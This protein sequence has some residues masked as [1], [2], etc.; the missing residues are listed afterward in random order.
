MARESL[1]PKVRTR[2]DVAGN[3]ILDRGRWRAT[4]P[5]PDRLFCLRD[6]E[7]AGVQT[8]PGR[9]SLSPPES[10]P[11]READRKR[12]WEWSASLGNRQLVRIGTRCSVGSSW[13]PKNSDFSN[14]ILASGQPPRRT[15]PQLVRSVS[16]KFSATCDSSQS[17]RHPVASRP[18]QAQRYGSQ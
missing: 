18:G 7:N 3:C 11:A 2:G 15:Y 4:P 9:R 8:S 12:G 10:V 5:P 14:P 6:R 13:A 1:P 16:C 17:A